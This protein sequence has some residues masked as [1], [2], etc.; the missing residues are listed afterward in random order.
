M[1]DYQRGHSRD[2]KPNVPTAKHH[3]AAEVTN[4]NLPKSNEVQTP[5][6]YRP[7]TLLNLDYKLLARIL[8]NRLRPVLEEHLR[9]SQFCSVPGNPTIEAVSIIREAVARAELTDTSL[10]V[11]NWIFWK[12][13]I[14]SHVTISSQY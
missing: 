13:S 2:T 14:G 9:T 5:E 6:A 1:E 10:C 3:A 7:I 11:L 8:A 4:Y 12:H